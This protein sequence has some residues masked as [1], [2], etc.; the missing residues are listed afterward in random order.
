MSDFQVTFKGE[1]FDVTLSARSAYEA[2]E[3]YKR[4]CEELNKA[5]GEA[6]AGSHR[7]SL[8]VKRAGRRPSARGTRSKLEESITGGFFKT[9]KQLKEIQEELA[10]KG[11]TKPVTHIAPYLTYF[12][13]N[14]MLEREQLLVGNRKVWVYKEKPRI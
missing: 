1:R 13:R 9:G 12:V 10:K 14:N 3:E 4:L 6:R 8:F 7:S 5:L 11:V 2:A